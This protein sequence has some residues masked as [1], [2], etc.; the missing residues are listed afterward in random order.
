MTRNPLQEHRLFW[1]EF[2]ENFHTTGAVLPS[3]RWLSSALTR[4]VRRSAGGIRILE[5]GPGTGVVT[6]QIVRRMG[7]DARLDLVELNESFVSLLRQRFCQDPRFRLVADRSRVIHQ[8]V[9]LFKTEEP[10]DTIISGLPLNNFDVDQVAQILAAYRRLLKP[11]GTLSFFEYIGVRP[12][13][14]LVGKPSDRHRLRGITRLLHKTFEDRTVRRE[15]IWPN[16][17]PAWV[18]HVR[19]RPA[20]APLAG[21]TLASQ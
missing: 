9:T 21:A 16:V 13:R 17:P 11:G 7:F 14:R 8:S 19:L 12:V 15:W 3:S 10:Y 2:R 20:P 18:H 6:K 4:Y 5:A 1:R